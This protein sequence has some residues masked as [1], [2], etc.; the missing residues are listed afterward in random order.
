MIEGD[1]EAGEI[2]LVSRRWMLAMKASGV[3]PGLFRRPA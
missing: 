3:T 2:A 1:A